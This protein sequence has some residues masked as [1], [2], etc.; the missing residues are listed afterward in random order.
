MRLSLLRTLGL[1]L[2]LA[3]LLAVSAGAQDNEAAPPLPSPEELPQLLG[4]FDVPGLALASLS[5]C[6]V[7][8][9]LVAGSATLGPTVPVTPQ[10]A[11]EAASLSK[12]VFAYL[13]LSLADDG[14]VDLDRPLALD[15]DYARIPDKAAYGQI[16]PRMALTHRTGLPNWVGEEVAF[17][18]RTTPIPFGTPPGTAYSYSGE[19]FQLLQAFVEHKTGKTLQRLFRERLGAV[20]PHS[21]FARPLPDSVVPSR[22]YRSASHPGSGRGM[23]NLHARGMA[24]AS[25]VTTAGDYAHFLSHVCHG[26]GPRP[27]TYADMWTPQS[28]VPE[29]EASVPTSYGLGWMLA[30]VG[31]GTFVGHGGN[32]DEY[33]ALAGF[34]R[35]SGDGMVVL[36]NGAGGEALIDVLLAPPPTGPDQS[37]SP[38]EAT[39][40]A[41]W[42]IYTVVP[43]AE[44]PETTDDKLWALLEARIDLLTDVDGTVPRALSSI[45]PLFSTRPIAQAPTVHARPLSP[46]PPAARR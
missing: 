36:T 15:L 18:E 16:T 17:H 11:F 12:P 25:L 26:R 30:D 45:S 20:M 23:T 6:A 7:D 27:D 10:T 46:R 29:E 38:P 39:F 19:A 44:G 1:V 9:V 5:G 21:T 40:E 28:P 24:A 41:F 34:L 14:L 35:E 8:T 2:A 33:R 43:A 37:L 42:A 3:G 22:G 13:V 32:N 31:T 4:A